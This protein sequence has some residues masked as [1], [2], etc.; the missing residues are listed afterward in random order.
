M[1]AEGTDDASST[2]A[3]SCGGRTTIAAASTPP[4]SSAAS[5]APSV[6]AQDEDASKASLNAKIEGL[7]KQQADMTSNKKKLAKDLRNEERK[8]RR[9]KDRAKQLT[10][11]DLLQVLRLRAEAKN[12]MLQQQQQLQMSHPST[13]Q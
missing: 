1:S 6:P 13:S 8:R 12:T 3:S 5:G 11:D 2:A 9:L 7:K 4:S 10:D